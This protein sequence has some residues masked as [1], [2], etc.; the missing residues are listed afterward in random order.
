MARILNV[1]VRKLDKDKWKLVE[2]L[3]YHV[4]SENSNEIIKV[5]AGFITDFASTPWGVRNLFPKDGTYTGAA[6]IHDFLYQNHTYSRKRCDS[7]FLEAMKVSG[8]PAWRRRTMWL[9][10][11]GFGWYSYNKNK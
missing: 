11:R 2:P 8:V 6:I 3:E 10:L 1:V 7:I 5:P 4:G 9:A